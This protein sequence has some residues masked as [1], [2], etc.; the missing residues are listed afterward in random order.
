MRANDFLGPSSE[1]ELDEYGV[2]V[3]Q[4]PTGPASLLVSSFLV[5]AAIQVLAASVY[6]RDEHHHSLLWPRV[7][8]LAAA[9]IAWIPSRLRRKA[10]RSVRLGAV[11]RALIMISSL[12]LVFATGLLLLEAVSPHGLSWCHH[13]CSGGY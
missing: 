3:V 6:I 12:I 13:N 4:P 11:G 7:A 5:C 2:P 8:A 10:F 1:P 9:L